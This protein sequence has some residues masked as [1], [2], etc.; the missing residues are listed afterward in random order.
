MT[1]MLKYLRLRAIGAALL[2]LA[3]TLCAAAAPSAAS[4]YTLTY[5]GKVTAA[6]GM[7]S[8]FGVAP[9]DAVAGSVGLENLDVW[10]DL[11][12]PTQLN[13]SFSQSP[14]PSLF[15]VNH[16]GAKYSF[17]VPGH[18]D[19]AS[20]LFQTGVSTLAL[21][22][23]GP[24]STLTLYYE[25]T[26]ANLPLQS[27]AGLTDWGQAPSLLSG[28]IASLF[29]K[30]EVPD[31]GSVTFSIALPA[32]P[33]ATTPIPAALPLFLSAMGGLGLFGWRRRGGQGAA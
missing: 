24:A 9:G 23:F 13:H 25:T 27:L 6:S 1:A 26:T 28:S 29:G 5:S 20:R 19:I 18:G 32:P 16:D 8:I 7:F 22:A 21:T 30:F 14:M 17:D 10:T 12:T 2:G 33:V 31:L 15:Q 11:S 3:V 4:T